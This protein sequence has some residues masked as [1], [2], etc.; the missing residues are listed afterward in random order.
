ML[1]NVLGDE[2]YDIIKNKINY[3]ILNEIRIRVDK[4]ILVFERGTPHFLGKEGLTNDSSRA[5]VATKQN[6]EDIVFRASE[7][8]VYSINEELKKGFIMLAGGERI[9][10]CGEVVVEGGEIKTIKNFTSLNIRVPHEVRNCSL[11]AFSYLHDEDGLKN[12]LVLSPPGGGKTTF[13]R[14]FVFQLS[15]RNYCYNV[16]IVDERAEIA[17]TNGSLNVGKFADVLSFTTKEIGFIQ[18]VRTMSPHLLVTDELGGRED[19]LALKEAVNCG[20]KVLATVH[21]S[22]LEELKSKEFYDEIKDTF[23]RFVVLS[24]RNGPGTFEG[25]YGKNFSRLSEWRRL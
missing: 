1:K 19:A 24:S 11:N 3:S 6:L 17:G 13:L 5:L 16:L 2:L 21:A 10:I 23:E 8:S 7:C 20:V 4:P 22:S 18:G 15:E 9:G 12:T 25:V 14:D